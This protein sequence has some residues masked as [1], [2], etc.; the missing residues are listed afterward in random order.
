MVLFK[1]KNARPYVVDEHNIQNPKDKK[2]LKIPNNGSRTMRNLTGTTCNY[3]GSLNV[4]EAHI[5]CL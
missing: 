5:L 4:I 2:T 3:L 1:V